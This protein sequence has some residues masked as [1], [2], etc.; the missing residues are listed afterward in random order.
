MTGCSI[1]EPP[2]VDNEAEICELLCVGEIAEP[3]EG[4]STSMSVLSDEVPG[5]RE[6]LE[7]NAEALVVVSSAG[8]MVET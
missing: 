2:V 4:V 6:T 1:V 5:S 7:D 8:D 3:I